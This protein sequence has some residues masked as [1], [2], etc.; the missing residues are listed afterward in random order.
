[1]TEHECP[2]CKLTIKSKV[3]YEDRIVT[4]LDCMKCKIPMAVSK[5]HTMKMGLYELSHI[6]NIILKLFGPAV[7]LHT[8][9][10]SIPEHWHTHI[11]V[12]E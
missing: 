8:D 9:Q 6:L 11:E 7:M 5:R 1:M 4:V 12:V 2:L 3:Y 10:R